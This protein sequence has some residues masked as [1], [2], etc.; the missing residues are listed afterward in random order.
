MEVSIMKTRNNKRRKGF[1]LIE[2]IVVIAILAILAAVAV[3]N[4]IGLTAKANTA[5]EV[6]TAAEYVNAINIANTMN[7]GTIS[8]AEE[9]KLVLA[10]V[11]TALGTLK[12]V[13][14]TG[15]AAKAILRITVTDGVAKVTKKS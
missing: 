9:G 8:D 2:L 14:E 11:D 6:A 13:S 4:F 7:A 1:T 3:P 10:T 12:P 15:I 5:V